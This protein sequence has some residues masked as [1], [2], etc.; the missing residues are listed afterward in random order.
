MQRA[1]NRTHLDAM[2]G[3]SYIDVQVPL[4]PHQTTP[5]VQAQEPR[6]DRE[7]EHSDFDAGDP[8]GG[9]KGRNGQGVRRGVDAIEHRC[10][11]V[12]VRVRGWCRSWWRAFKALIL[13]ESGGWVRVVRIAA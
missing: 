2:C 3:A 9:V 6:T 11:K 8:C 12:S 10:M 5:S 13:R 7:E 1:L 4:L